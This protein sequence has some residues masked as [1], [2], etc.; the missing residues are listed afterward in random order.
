M[1]LAFAC[2]AH[3]AGG[4]HELYVIQ[5]KPAAVVIVDT[6]Q[7]TIAGKIPIQKDP[8]YA[9]VGSHGHFLYVLHGRRSF[10]GM[11]YLKPSRLSV[12]DLQNRR[13]ARVIQ[14]KAGINRMQLSTDGRTLFC[15]S[16]GNGLKPH[17]KRRDDASIT[18]ID[19][20]SQQVKYVYRISTPASGILMTRDGSR[21]FAFTSSEFRGMSLGA[22]I[23][24]PTLKFK[25][26]SEQMT[27]FTSGQEQ[28]VAT[29][30][31][32]RYY[33]TSS[34]FSPN[35]RLLFLLG[36][37]HSLKGKLLHKNGTLDVVNVETGKVVQ[38][39]TVGQGP[40]RLVRLAHQPGL[41]IVGKDKM[42]FISDQG[43]LR[44]GQIFLDGE[45]SSGSPKLGG[46]P[47][48]LLAL[49]GGRVAVSIVNKNG[50][51]DHRLALLD[52][53][54]QKVE[55]V[56]P[57]GRKGKRAEKKAA[58]VGLAFGLGFASA[59][60]AGAAGSPY[61]PAFTPSLSL[62]GGTSLIRGANG[63]DF[64]ALDAASNGL[65]VVKSANGAVVSHIPIDSSSFYLWIPKSG[66]Y[67]FCLGGNKVSVVDTDTNK[68]L[69]EDKLAGDL[70]DGEINSNSSTLYL[71]TSKELD[72][73][74]GKGAKRIDSITGFN[75]A[76][77]I[78][79]GEGLTP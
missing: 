51:T 7:G 19:T 13:V 69:T 22:L 78:A 33:P 11:G 70:A 14:L 67:L 76:L 23:G 17:P 65:T 25:Y 45:G 16:D 27:V 42:Q 57:V 73:W 79:R 50:A 15:F 28:P 21:I 12:V 68:Q 10:M 60:A 1:V 24:K 62:S 63:N 46:Y 53:T 48:E 52:L 35:Q 41:W 38:T 32:H 34:A 47:G 2:A 37:S 29:A 75:H 20:A 49:P 26:P 8:T 31:L 59:G 39:Y 61:Y 56:V 64:Y 43:V 18:A 44:A 77:L 3:G 55:K 74:D 30:D 40:L 5:T 36:Q 58:R 66:R 54:D 9:I 71:L 4:N 72:I 6:S